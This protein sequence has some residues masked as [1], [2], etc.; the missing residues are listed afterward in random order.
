MRLSLRIVKENC[1]KMKLQKSNKW[2]KLYPEAKTSV[3]QQPTIIKQ[4][5][6]YLYNTLFRHLILPRGKKSLF[7]EEVENNPTFSNSDVNLKFNKP[8]INV[9]IDR[10]NRRV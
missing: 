5:G 1:P 9:T 4:T 3:T 6:V 7:M 2:T 10:E 8:E